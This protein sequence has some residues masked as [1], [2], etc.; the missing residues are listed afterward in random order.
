MGAIGQ[1]RRSSAAL[2]ERLVKDRVLTHINRDNA[3]G[4]KEEGVFVA[5]PA[6]L[7]ERVPLV[8]CNMIHGL[9]MAAVQH[10]RNGPALRKRVG[11]RFNKALNAKL[12][13][14]FVLQSR[15]KGFSVSPVSCQKAR[16]A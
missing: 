14:H 13:C 6:D 8:A 9:A 4:R 11:H 12:V 10:D 3:R 2:G 5:V 15:F 7:N 16:A 1:A